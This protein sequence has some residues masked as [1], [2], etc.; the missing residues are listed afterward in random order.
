[1]SDNAITLSPNLPVSPIG[2][3]RKSCVLFQLSPRVHLTN[4]ST[5]EER[6]YQ[7][8][9]SSTRLRASSAAKDSANAPPPSPATAAAPWRMWATRF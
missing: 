4:L 1:M 9:S 8:P 5:E 3:A 2:E 6:C 7:C